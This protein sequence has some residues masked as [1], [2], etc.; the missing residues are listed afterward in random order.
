MITQN[1]LEQFGPLSEAI[2][3]KSAIALAQITRNGIHVDVARLGAVRQR[4]QERVDR[5]VAAI[6]AEPAWH[7]LLRYQRDGRLLLTAKGRTP[8]LSQNRLVELLVDAARSVSEK[9]GEPITI[10]RTEKGNVSRKADDWEVLAPFHPFIET[11]LELGNVAKLLQFFN[12]LQGTVLHPNYTPLVRT[13]RT[14]CSNPNIQNLPR[15]GGLREA[16]DPAPG[17][18]FLIV[19]YSF[20]ELRTLA[21]VCEARYEFS[22][23][24]DVIRAGI[25]PHA[26]TAAMFE[27]MELDAFMALKT[28]EDPADRERFD[29]LRQRA[30]VINFGIPGGLGLR[31]IVA[32]ARST[33]GVTLTLEEAREFRERLINEVYPELA[34]YLA[35]DGMDV[36]AFNLGAA[37]GECWKTLDWKGDR[38]GRLVG[39]IRN[40]VEGKT[41][42]ADGKPYDSRF[43]KGVWD[44]LNTLNR[45]AELRPHLALRKG[46]E[47]LCRRLFRGGV[48][49]LTGRVRGRVGFTQAR[50]TPFQGL[51]ADGAKLALWALVRAGYRVVAFVHDEFVIELPEDADHTLEARKIE[52]LLNRE[53]ENVT[54]GVPV[55]CEYALARRWSKRAKPRFDDSGRLVVCEIAPD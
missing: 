12:G 10:A 49:T 14:S 18:L 33:Y 11:W 53:M 7:G 27:R 13:G 28:S 39:G 34:L 25:D 47:E 24:A 8:S 3:V 51:A 20:I 31:A 4:L 41:R 38:S 36:L 44:G 46:S 42:C 26:Y 2:Q 6:E 52:A 32:Y 55:A 30:K 16:F 21:A 23:L 1:A 40:L 5:L 45:N 48:I 43:I 22:K 9:T 17:H 15:K 35:N 37:P 29:T 54:G 19:D 50:N